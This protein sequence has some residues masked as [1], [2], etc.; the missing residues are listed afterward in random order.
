MERNSWIEKA[1]TE[2]STHDV[3]M[4]NYLRTKGD[5]FRPIKASSI[6]HKKVSSIE[7][8]DND[9][10]VFKMVSDGDP[11]TNTDLPTEEPKTTDVK[12]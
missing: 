6:L 11:D 9:F 10:P 5:I 12:Y 7:D 2:K 4:E 3:A 1:N 8:L